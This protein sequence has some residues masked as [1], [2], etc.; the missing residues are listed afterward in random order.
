MAAAPAKSDDEDLS[1]VCWR[2][3]QWLQFFPLTRLSALDYFALSPFYDRSCNNE[4]A[5]LQGL[6]PS[7]VACAPILLIKHFLGLVFCVLLIC[8]A[9]QL[10]WVHVLCVPCIQG[11][12]PI[13]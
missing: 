4:Q 2:D 12:N 10:Q 1:G 3:D 6:D 7:K 8:Y 9:L 5:K 11:G 13:A